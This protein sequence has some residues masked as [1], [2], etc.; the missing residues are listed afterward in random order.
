MREEKETVRAYYD[1]DPRKESPGTITR[2]G[3][4]KKKTA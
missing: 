4:A 3:F 2:C 1:S